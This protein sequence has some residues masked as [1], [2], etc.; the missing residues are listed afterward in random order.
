MS[1]LIL[2]I[3]CS[4]II[5]N[6]MVAFNRDNKSD[7]LLI[8]LGN[9]FTATIFSLI[10]NKSPF[11]DIR[12]FELIAGGLSGILFL[13]NF[14]IYRKNIMVNGM[15]LSVSIMRISLVIPILV[16][17]FFFRE[18]IFFF[19]FIGIGLILLSFILMADAGTFRSLGW[20][21]MLIFVTGISETAMKIYNEFGLPNHSLF[22]L[23]LFASA[24][25]TNL[26]II[27]YKRKKI[28]QKS[29]GQGMILGIPNQLSTVF[30]LKSLKSI[31]AS[32]AALI[33]PE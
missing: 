7:I 9:Y 18:S 22:V 28:T 24:L 2:S 5:A 16:S 20:I 32:T 21:F 31:P 8:F 19:N 6:L 12:P 3:L 29:F 25:L 23:I 26:I 27:L 11:S 14:L 33:V 10:S 13:V 15:S 4:V 30:F 1:F 17:L